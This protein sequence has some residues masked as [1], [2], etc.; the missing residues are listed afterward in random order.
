MTYSQA[1]LGFGMVAL[2]LTLVP[3]L[4]TTLVLRSA[5]VR[6][7]GY[8]VMTG[9]G[10]SA[11]A[12][13]WGVAAAVGASA[14]LAASEVAYRLVTLGGALYMGYLGASLIILTFRRHRH[15]QAVESP[16]LPAQRGGRV[17][18]FLSGAG[19][20]ILNPKVGVFYLAVIPQFI[21]VGASPL[22]MGLVLASVHVVLTMA[23]FSV[24]IVGAQLARRWLA[25][26]RALTIIDRVAGVVLIGFGARLALEQRF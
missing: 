2:V 11:G 4:D 7:R 15:R 18:A 20:N 24:I 17:R 6:G 16:E 22:A 23:W 9:L 12:L 10:V 3:G 14:L 19:T 1:I 13:I 5:L 21:P 25:S 8:A 26:E